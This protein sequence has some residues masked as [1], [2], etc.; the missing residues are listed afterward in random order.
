[1]R[2]I[3]NLA[4][5]RAATGAC[6][7]AGQRLALVPTMGALHDGHLALVTEARRHAEAVVVS[8]FVNPLQFLPTEDL[9]RYPRDEAGDLRKLEAIGTDLVWMPDVPTMYPAPPR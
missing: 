6:R 4:A 7:M 1:M 9:A 2:V 3:R 8:I 5:L